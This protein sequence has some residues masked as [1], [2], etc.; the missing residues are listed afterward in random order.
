MAKLTVLTECPS[1]TEHYVADG[2]WIVY[3]GDDRLFE[4]HL[5]AREKMGKH[6][7]PFV[8]LGGIQQL[9]SPEFQSDREFAVRQLVKSRKFHGTQKVVLVAHFNCGA[10]KDAVAG[11]SREEEV[12][13][14]M[15]ELAKAK[16]FVLYRQPDLK[17]IMLF[18][19]FDNIYTVEL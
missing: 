1:S 8:T 19:D 15:G 11:M 5:K 9:A 17:V 3:C 7:D 16:D 6:L 18:V 10:Y 4:S 2:G 14:Y 13:F 12:D